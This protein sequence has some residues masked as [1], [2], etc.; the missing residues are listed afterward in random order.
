VDELCRVVN[1]LSEDIKAQI[2][3]LFPAFSPSSSF[4]F[5]AFNPSSSTSM[6]Y[7]RDS[8]GPRTLLRT[9]N[10]GLDKTV[11]DAQERLSYCS[12]IKMRQEVQF[13]DP[14]PSQLAYPT[15][16]ERHEEKRAERARA[17]DEKKKGGNT[18]GEGD[19]ADSRHED[20]GKY[21]GSLCYG[22]ET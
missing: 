16:I 15:I 9:L 6:S 13:F 20:I 22:S 14:L 7:K 12:E 2:D 3:G 5:S 11:S 21:H 19:E 17:R 18:G 1:T 8:E 10:K 4:A